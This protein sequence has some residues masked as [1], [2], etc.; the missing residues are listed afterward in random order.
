MRTGTVMVE[1][2]QFEEVLL[3]LGREVAKAQKAERLKMAEHLH[4][5]I[6][7]SLLVAKMRLG[8]LSDE[9]PEQYVDC[10]TGVTEIISDLIHRTRANIEDL[11]SSSLCHVELKTGLASLAR[12]VQVKHGV[13]CSVHLDSMPDHL[14]DEAKQVLYRAVR[15]LLCNV[16]KH[17]R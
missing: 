12:D 1:Q 9:L 5:E 6:G 8:M 14:R 10:V 4:D 13:V 15:E 3:D 11:Y 2:H 7:Q 17:A 16:T